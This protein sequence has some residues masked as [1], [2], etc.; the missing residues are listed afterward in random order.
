MQAIQINSIDKKALVRDALKTAIS[1]HKYKE[2]IAQYAQNGTNSGAQITESLVN[3]TMLN[4]RRMKRLGKTLHIEPQMLKTIN[5]R[6]S[7]VEWLLITES[8]CGDAAQSTPMMEKFA[9]QNPNISLKVVFRDEQPKLMEAFL[10][11]GAKSIPKLIAF[12]PEADTI[13]GDWGPRPTKAAQL[14]ADYKAQN[15]SLSPEFKQDLQVWYNK[16]K[17]QDIANDLLVFF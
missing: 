17:G 3:Y 13:I 2:L 8:W 7:P 11:N 10:T 1:Y 16:D 12:D 9:E 6:K 5:T 15:G 14:V 4:H